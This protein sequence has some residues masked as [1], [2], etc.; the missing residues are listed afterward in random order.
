MSPRSVDDPTAPNDRPTVV[1]LVGPSNAGKTSL[2]EDLV[3]AFDDR[4]VAAIKSI[5][6]EIE[7]DEPGTDT[8]RHRC[9]GAEA[10]VGVTPTLTF[11]IARGGKGADR[12]AET[13]RDALRRVLDRL[14]GRGH[15][16]VLVEGF[17]A[18]VL[19]TIHLGTDAGSDPHAIGT[20]SDSI[21][22]LKSAIEATEPV[23][24]SSLSVR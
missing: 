19:P 1:A 12:D 3:A 24:P 4:S 7:P 2:V 9:A 14:A 10:V 8:H 20:G 23:D 6:H 17:S 18:V 11:E 22:R 5:H 21:E 15:D 16:L 13:E